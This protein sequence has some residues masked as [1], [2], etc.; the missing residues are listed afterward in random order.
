MV[1][2]SELLN[3]VNLIIPTITPLSSLTS[4]PKGFIALSGAKLYFYTGSAWALITS[5]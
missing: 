5:A 1:F 2:S 3:P 4:P